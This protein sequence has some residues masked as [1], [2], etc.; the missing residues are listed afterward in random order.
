MTSFEILIQ[1]NLYFWLR[2]VSWNQQ[3]NVVELI[4]ERE[5]IAKAIK[6]GI[7]HNKTFDLAV[8]L[9]CVSADVMMQI[10]GSRQWNSMAKLA[11]SRCLAQ[12]DDYLKGRLLLCRAKYL[13]RQEMYTESIHI[14]ADS[15]PIVLTNQDADLLWQIFY[16][17]GL[18]Q[19]KIGN[20]DGAHQSADE[21]DRLLEKFTLLNPDLC[22]GSVGMLCSEISIHLPDWGRAKDSLKFSIHHLTKAGTEHHLFKAYFLLGE[23]YNRQEKFEDALQAWT[24][25]LELLPEGFDFPTRSDLIVKTAQLQLGVGDIEQAEMLLQKIDFSMLRLLECNAIHLDA[26]LAYGRL[27]EAQ[28]NFKQAELIFEDAKTLEAEIKS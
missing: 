28:G 11:L 16:Y 1:N 8:H 18:N 6:K 22:K 17:K 27:A 7:A 25:S 9:L 23:Y 2:H 15:A 12:K 10:G 13:Y 20:L 3:V 19:L 5:N 14:L 4:A 21:I 26:V 24:R